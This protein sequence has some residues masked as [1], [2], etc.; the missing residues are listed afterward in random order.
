[1]TSNVGSTEILSYREG[2]SEDAYESMRAEVMELLKRESADGSHV[3]VDCVDGEFTF[4]RLDQARQ[5]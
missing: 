3:Q 4:E 2:G 5:E 1:M